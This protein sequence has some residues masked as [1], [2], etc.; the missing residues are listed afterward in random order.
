[1]KK[2]K[3]VTKPVPKK[4]SSAARTRKLSDELLK[5][6]TGGQLGV[7]KCRCTICQSHCG[8]QSHCTP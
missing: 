3:R 7:C 1:M 8:A 5:E 6:I 4:S 2:S